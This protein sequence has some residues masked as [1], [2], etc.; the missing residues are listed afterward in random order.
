MPPL[1][2]SKNVDFDA[3]GLIAWQVLLDA[4]KD[5]LAENLLFL[6]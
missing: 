2:L 4:E 3:N 5:A 1:P 6:N